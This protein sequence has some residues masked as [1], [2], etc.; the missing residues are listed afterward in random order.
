MTEEPVP[1]EVEQDGVLGKTPPP[2][3]WCMTPG[4]NSLNFDHRRSA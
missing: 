1:E 3:T 2:T 4:S